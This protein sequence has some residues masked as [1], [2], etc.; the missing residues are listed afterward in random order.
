MISAKSE[1]GLPPAECVYAN[2]CPLYEVFQWDLQITWLVK[3]KTRLKSIWKLNFCKTVAYDLFPNFLVL[4]DFV[5]CI[6]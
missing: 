6:F 1:Q 5:C 3:K 4:L 2:D